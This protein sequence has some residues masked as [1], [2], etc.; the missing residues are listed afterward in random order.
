MQGYVDL[1][2]YLEFVVVNRPGGWNAWIMLSI[3]PKAP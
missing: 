1:K 3:S 2:V